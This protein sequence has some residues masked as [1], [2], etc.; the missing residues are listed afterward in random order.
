[1][2]PTSKYPRIEVCLGRNPA[3][4]WQLE[5]A[6]QLRARWPGGVGIR[7][8]TRKRPAS[9]PLLAR[10]IR[11]LEPV[12]LAEYELEASEFGPEATGVLLDF[13]CGEG[14]AEPTIRAALPTLRLCALGGD[15]AEQ[16]L[17]FAAELLAGEPSTSVRLELFTA[18]DGASADSVELGRWRV[19][20][21]RYVEF[22]N[23]VLGDLPKAIERV[24]HSIDW[25]GPPRL[26]GASS[27]LG[28]RSS[29]TRLFRGSSFKIFGCMLLGVGRRLWHDLFRHEQWTIGIAEAPIGTFL[30]DHERPPI[31]WL[32]PRSRREYLA[33]PFGVDLADG[34]LV[35]AER[36]DYLRA[37]GTIV[38]LR[39][40]DPKSEPERQLSLEYDS[41]LSYPFLV[42][43]GDRLLGIP[44]NF[45]SNAI[46]LYEL[47]PEH[48]SQWRK[49]RVLVEPFAGVDATVLQWNGRWWLFA[50]DRDS[51]PDSHLY[52]WH[53]P[54]VDGPW[55]PHMFNPV[56]ID[57]GSARP[58]G[59]PFVVDGRLYRPAQDCTHT[60]GA[61][62]AINEITRLTPT[63]FE[64]NVVSYVTPEEGSAWP[65]G[66][67]TLSACGERLT[68]LDAKRVLFSPAAM[69]SAILN[70]ARNVIT[71][72]RSRATVDA[73]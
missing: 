13:S 31:R 44:E 12:D 23:G 35:Y 46:S 1:V 36:L 50:T 5:I 72:F 60:Y 25:Q 6:S 61:R 22:A 71:R 45:Q 27:A 40:N 49:R 38:A 48:P 16:G 33:D 41:H 59:T 2:T 70:I 18:G 14:G 53:A 29:T 7:A 57:V 10:R 26:P 32:P 30:N 66:L 62:V 73:N 34:L 20:P 67:H 39:F 43:D 69:W 37:K 15:L 63:A 11:A 58:G 47:D 17:P 68:L 65:D 21:E 64:E 55:T 4:R 8:G 51:G 3:P 28:D 9:T 42:S 52:V 24:L 19:T 56:K 54:V